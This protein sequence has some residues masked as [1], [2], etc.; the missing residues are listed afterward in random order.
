MIT[1]RFVQHAGLFHRPGLFNRLCEFAQYGFPYT[2][3]EGKDVSGCYIGARLFGGV[4]R[5]DHGYD[6]GTVL[7][8][9]Q[10][11][12]RTTDEQS[13]A[14]YA[15]LLEQVGKP[16][17]PIQIVYFINGRNWQDPDAWTCSEL[18]AAGIVAAGI[19]PQK[20]ADIYGAI[21]V[22]GLMLMIS[23]LAEVD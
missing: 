7:L 22:Q 3:V 20:M 2:H 14:F 5:R 12:V 4:Q 9:Q 1:L 19:V 21:T 8:E 17:D 13:E 6:T 18:I 10:I 23:P 15:F 16:Y 11:N